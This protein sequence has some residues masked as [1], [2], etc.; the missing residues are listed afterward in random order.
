MAR[1]ARIVVPGIPHHVTQRGVRRMEVFT[2]DT[3]YWRF[4]SLLERQAHIHSLDIWAYCL[5]PNHFHLIAAPARPDGLAKPLAEAQRRYAVEFNQRLRCTGHL[6]QERYSSSPM[7]EPHLMAAIRYVLLNPVRAGLVDSPVDWPYSSARGHI[8]G[9]R[10]GL[11]NPAPAAA[12]IHEW[13][14]YL[15]EG[16]PYERE[17]AALCRLG[18]VGRPLGSADFVL[19]LE[20]RT[21]RRLRPNKVGRK[22]KQ[23]R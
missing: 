20:R 7:D 4:L 5:M 13:Q 14:A 2:A 6:W 12:R 16:Q 19:E 8:M 17:T 9:T 10:D 21:G 22:R 15:D 3:D 18:P 1:F 11:L 23:T